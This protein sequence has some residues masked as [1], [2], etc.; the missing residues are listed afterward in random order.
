MR[1]LEPLALLKSDG[2]GATE[3]YQKA[4]QLGWTTVECIR[5]LRLVY[6]LSLSDAKAVRIAIEHDG[7]SL[8]D[9]Q[10]SLLPAIEAAAKGLD[11]L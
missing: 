10:E 7:M 11:D 5:M 1:D 8:S 4:T 2:V 9:Y 6:G 3:A